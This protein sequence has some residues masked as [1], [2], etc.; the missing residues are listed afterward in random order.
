MLRSIPGRG[1]IREFNNFLQ[2]VYYSHQE[3]S[4][5]VIKDLIEVG[6]LNS[7][8]DPLATSPIIASPKT[9]KPAS[10]AQQLQAALQKNNFNKT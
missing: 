4:P 5:A 7:K 1:N 10:E 6:A 3:P 8:T 9:K 2:R